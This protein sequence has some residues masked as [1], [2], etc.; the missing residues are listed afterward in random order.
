MKQVKI[1]FASAYN[2]RLHLLC[3]IIFAIVFNLH[4]S[5]L[6][7]I[8]FLFLDCR[9]LFLRHDNSGKCIS[10]GNSVYDSNWANPRW[11]RMIDNCLQHNA[12]FRYLDTEHLQNINTTG[13]FASASH[14]NYRLGSI[15]GIFVYKRRDPRSFKFQNGAAHHLKQTAAGSLSLYRVTVCPEPLQSGDNDTYVERKTTCDRPEQTFTL[16]K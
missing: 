8:F 6:N 9:S 16:G 15:Y 13:T 12:Q 7:I 1:G 4:S 2:S 10:A 3:T 11:A 14:E 5:L